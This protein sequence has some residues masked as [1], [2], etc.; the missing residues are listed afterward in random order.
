MLSMNRI[1]G[2]SVF[3]G[4][5]RRELLKI[6]ACGALG[7][8]LADLLRLQAAGEVQAA[9]ASA[10]IQ[11]WLA[12]GPPQT[13]TFDP[14][15]KA[16]PAVAGPLRKPLTTNVPG[17]EISELLP[18]LAQQAD[19]YALLRGMTHGVNAHETAAYIMQTGSMPAADLVYPAVGAVVAYKRNEAGY[20]G[21]L[22]PYIT[23]PR[24]LGRFSECGFLGPEYKTFATGGNA[25]ADV[26]NVQGIVPPAGMTD[27]RLT[28]RRKLLKSLD[29]LAESM[30]ANDRFAEMDDYQRRAYGL[31]LGDAKQAFVM[32][33]ETPAMRDRYGRNQWGQSMLLARRLV[34][35]GVPFVTVNYGGWDT[36]RDNFGRLKTLAPPLD[37]GLAAL[38]ADL[39]E[40]GLLESTIVT[41][42][43][44]FGRTPKIQAGAPWD[45]GRHHFSKVFSAL[46]AGGGF[47]GGAVVGASDPSGERVQDRP[48]YPWD[49]SGSIYQLLGINPHGKLPHPHGCVAYVTPPPTKTPTK[50]AKKPD[51]NNGKRGEPADKYPGG[52]L[53]TEIMG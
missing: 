48:T 2:R 53:L 6:G 3:G 23:V 1:S 30:E 7:L 26:V 47:Q 36:H 9:P 16:G 8:S 38:L 24:P 44:E 15:P 11:I 43:G 22:P 12:G 45:G 41:C 42:Y 37:Q 35:R 27:A 20:A 5:S 4:A 34:E 49:L 10:V 52:G 18:N 50:P 29:S 39:D 17:I 33:E 46:V 19:K 31:I 14:K 32:K 40:R 13:D 28:E 25:T 51:Q 21:S